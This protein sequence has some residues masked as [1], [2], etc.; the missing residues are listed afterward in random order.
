MDNQALKHE[1]DCIAHRMVTAW[2]DDR[3]GDTHLLMVNGR[4]TLFRLSLCT[5]NGKL[6]A[7]GAFKSWLSC[8]GEDTDPRYLNDWKYDLFRCICRH[9]VAGV[10]HMELRGWKAWIS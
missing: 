10:Y 7:N 2:P 9:G 4:E 5:M 8:R 6:C 1:W 3:D